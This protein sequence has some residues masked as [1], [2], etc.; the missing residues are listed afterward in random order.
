MLT[1]ILVY[2]ES[3]KEGLAKS[4]SLLKEKILTTVDEMTKDFAN[5]NYEQA[6]DC[7]AADNTPGV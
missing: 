7:T 2:R 3:P 5:G 1:L 6:I 4:V